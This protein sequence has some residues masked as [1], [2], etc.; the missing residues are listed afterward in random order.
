MHFSNAMRF[1]LLI[2]I[3]D[4]LHF[5]FAGAKQSFTYVSYRKL[6]KCGQLAYLLKPHDLR[7]VLG[8][9]CRKQ[10]KHAKLVPDSSKNEKTEPKQG[11]AI[12]L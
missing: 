3:L 4:E 2:L 1:V 5:H 6:K 8:F 11:S 10:K 9:C 7:R 12:E